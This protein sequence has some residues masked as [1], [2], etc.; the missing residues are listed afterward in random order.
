MNPPE[1]DSLL[2]EYKA[3][4]GTPLREAGAAHYLKRGAL[5]GISALAD[6]V[7]NVYNLGKAAI[8]ASEL[9]YLLSRATGRPI[10]DFQPEA[11]RASPIANFLLENFDPS[12]NEPVQPSQKIGGKWGA[13]ALEGVG[14]AM[15]QG[16]MGL[17]RQAPAQ[18]AKE[19]VKQEVRQAAVGAAG[20]LGAEAGGAATGDSTLGRIVGG[21]VGGVAVPSSFL[22][23]GG[24]VVGGARAAA[25]TAQELAQG[26]PAQAQPAFKSYIQGQLEAAVAGDPNAARNITEA[27]AIRNKIPGF[28]PSVGEMSGTPGLLD[29]QRKFT[30]LNPQ[31]LNT[32]V[33][34]AA[35]DKAA[36]E[37]FFKQTVPGGGQPSSVRSS[38]NQSLASEQGRIEQGGVAT[39]RQLPVADQTQLGTKL[40]GAAGKEK[41]A[42][43]PPIDAAYKAAFDAAGGAKAD[44][45]GIVAKV[46]D[47]LG[48]KLTEIN[49]ANAPATVAAIKRIYG[50][51]SGELTG[52]YIPPD[53]MEAAGLN[54]PKQASLKDLHDIRVAIGQDM[55]AAQRS[56][57]VAA[58]TRLYKLR[59]VMPE[60]DK[61]IAAMPEGAAKL[62]GEALN[63]YKTEY[64]PR[65]KEGTP[66]QVFKE[67]SIN[68]PKIL[69]DRFVA[70]FFKPDSQAG[71]TRATQFQKLFGSNA[72]AKD[73]AKTGILDIY[74]QRVIDPTTGTINPSA[75]NAFLRDY[76]R[77]LD[78]WK[79]GGVD[80]A[81]E[82]RRIGSEAAKISA[83]GAKLDTLARSLRFDTVDEL[84]TAALQSPKVMGNV[85]SR[86]DQ[87]G[88]QTLGSIALNRAWQSGSAAN[89][90][91]FLSDNSGTLKML[92]SPKQLSDLTD[93]GRALEIAER[94][95]VHGALASGGADILKNA[96]GLSAA[97]VFAQVRAVTAARSSVAWG[98]INLAL[99]VANKLSQTSF[100]QVMEDALHNPQTATNLR[101]ALVAQNLS[102]AQN[103]LDK[104]VRGLKTTGTM[105][106][107]ARGPIIK[108]FV[109]PQN[110]PE[111]LA[112]SAATLE[113][114]A[115]PDNKR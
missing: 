44:V 47:V 56:N 103:W 78:N 77:T 81:S 24:V 88:R 85:L 20:G 18:M 42:A 96:T 5:Q 49:P 64:V 114:T 3:L 14:A 69:P 101:N 30:M 111:N 84:T 108:N 100:A 95:P 113:A 57:D 65:F 28:N 104:L 2:A 115:E 74:R 34:R 109:G 97:T 102:Q 75:H 87:S 46:E 37:A 27:L 71:A 110:Y 72:E 63:K 48:S 17:V 21:L 76:G 45:A 80:A 62:Y 91:K 58:A 68:E 8:G 67:K 29:M 107:S 35:A 26:V 41:A 90:N 33:A 94:A 4:E 23:Q 9:P 22:R 1:L 60:V 36:I 83:A 12:L 51:K 50:D 53:L 10:S 79:V 7:P 15:T 61:A 86:L 54:A 25:Q 82:I 66:G 43:R 31:N 39:A 92:V 105:A 40:I 52:R 59:D 16:P 73:A 11:G 19:L 6:V 89:F 55:A 106:W 99:P 70:E 112:R 32:E 38:V 13:A 98:A 93:I